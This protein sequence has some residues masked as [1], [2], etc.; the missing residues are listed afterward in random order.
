MN[1]AGAVPGEEGVTVHE[2]VEETVNADT[3]A[4][5]RSRR[6]SS[7]E[8]IPGTDQAAGGPGCSG[9]QKRPAEAGRRTGP[10]AAAQL[11]HS[12]DYWRCQVLVV[13]SGP[14]AVPNGTHSVPRV[15]P[16]RAAMPAPEIC[17]E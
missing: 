9:K 10:G 7:Q 3:R 17:H 14:T 16:W 1:L 5:A 8:G 2:V 15:L 12:K 11:K 6:V 4:R 13:P